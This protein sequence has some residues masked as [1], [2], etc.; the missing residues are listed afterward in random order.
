MPRHSC[1]DGPYDLWQASDEGRYANELVRAFARNPRLPKFLKAN[2]VVDT[3]VQGIDRGLFVAELSRPDG[4]RRT[5]WREVPPREVMDDDQLRVVLPD[6]AE[7]GR[8]ARKTPRSGGPC[9]ARPLG[10]RERDAGGRDRVFPERPCRDRVS[11]WLRRGRNRSAMRGGGRAG[12]D[13]HG[14]FAGCDLVDERPHFCLV[15]TGSGG[16]PHARGNLA[17]ATGTDSGDFIGGGRLP[18]GVA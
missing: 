14:G 17:P 13:S 4:S 16:R 12:G 10:R 2:V 5:W 6:K 3:V 15:R 7:P 1:P 18:R 11:R 9:S 8:A